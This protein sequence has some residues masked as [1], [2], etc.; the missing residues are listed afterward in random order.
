MQLVLTEQRWLR[1]TAFTALYFAQGVPIGLLTVAIPAW[2]GERGTGLAEVSAY[3]GVVG[4]PWAFK[5]VAGPFMD[6]FSFLAMGFRRPWVMA[7]Q[8]GL[9]VSF[10]ALAAF[11]DLDGGSLVSL[12]ALGF[13]VNAFAAMQDVAVDGMAIDI[14][15]VG[16]RGR[17]NAFMG[18]G[19]VAGFSSFGALSATLLVTVGMAVTALVCAATVAVIFVFVTVVR[20]RHGERRLPWSDGRPADVQRRVDASWRGVFRDLLRVLFLPMSLVLTLVEFLN[21][22]RDGIASAVLPVFSTQELGFTTEQYGQFIAIISFAA[23]V[24]AVFIG[25]L[26]DRSGA[27]R[28]LMIALVGAAVTHLAAGLLPAHW[29]NL[30]FMLVLAMLAYAFGQLVFVAIIAL[31]M[32]ICWAVIAATQFAIYMSLANLSRTIGSFGFASVADHLTW[33]QDFLLMAAFLGASALVL[34]FFRMDKHEERLRALDAS[35]AAG[36]EQLDET[37]Q[38]ADVAGK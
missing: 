37:V 35:L 27:R 11:G 10:L 17:A 21:R 4:I 9:V 38:D 34:V 18:F 33:E 15:P 1:F 19:Q 3:L 32:N 25:P 14:L 16:E 2:L 7:M 20:E 13:V 28:F 29:P 36:A 30:T 5:L 6:R 22:V 8:G 23:A 24:F 31:Y 12:M 26:I